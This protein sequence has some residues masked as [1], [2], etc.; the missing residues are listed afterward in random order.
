MKEKVFRN[1]VVNFIIAF[2]VLGVFSITYLSVDTQVH[3]NPDGAISRGNDSTKVSLMF[4]V[5]NGTEYIDDILRVLDANKVSATFF[6]GGSWIANNE[7]TLQRIAHYGHEIGN[8]G[9]FRLDHSTLGAQRNREEILATHKLVQAMLNISMT[10]FSPPQ[11]VFNKHTIQ[12]ANNLGYKTIMWTT[13]TQDWKE[14][15]PE[16]ITKRATERLSGGDFILMQPTKATVQALP[17]ILEAISTKGFKIS[18]IREV[19]DN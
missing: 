17:K 8:H 14:Q 3:A 10:N 5:Y 6:V 19:V 12:E 1:V 9:Y 7:E 13:D 15:D 16:L 18:M 2:V 4:N 11:G